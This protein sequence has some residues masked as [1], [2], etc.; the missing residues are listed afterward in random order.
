M[1]TISLLWIWIL[2]LWLLSWC[3]SKEAQVEQDP[4]IEQMVSDDAIELFDE[5]AKI[6]I[7]GLDKQEIEK[8]K[9]TGI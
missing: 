2:S 8:L 1:K 7:D 4:M 9:G 5:Q 3:A 6:L